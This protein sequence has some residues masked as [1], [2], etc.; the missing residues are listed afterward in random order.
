[1]LSKLKQATKDIEE[2]LADVEEV[3][4]S[5]TERQSQIDR[6]IIDLEHEIELENYPAHKMMLKYKE[7]KA[8][9]RLRRKYKNEL[10]Y[11]MAIR[12]SLNLSV[13]SASNKAL[14]AVVEKM[15]RKRYYHR[16]KEELRIE[17]L[18][19]AKKI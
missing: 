9:F 6:L 1:M 17:I 15:E 2:I 4:K 7:L 3:Y 14:H 8:C 5:V 11:L 19:E 13:V 10:E 12:P 18:E 16:I